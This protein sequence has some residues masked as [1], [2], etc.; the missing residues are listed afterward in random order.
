MWHTAVEEY[1]VEMWDF[2]IFIKQ[3]SIVINIVFIDVERL[4]SE[5]IYCVCSDWK[6]PMPDDR[7]FCSHRLLMWRH[8]RCRLDV[9]C[10][11]STW[12]YTAQ[13]VH[14]HH[15]PLLLMWLGFLC[16]RTWLFLS[17]SLSFSLSLSLSLSLSILLIRLMWLIFKIIHDNV[18]F[19]F[20][21]ISTVFLLPVYALN[22]IHCGL[23][24]L[25]NELIWWTVW[26]RYG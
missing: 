13:C 4:L 14:I 10:S 23:M 16:L 18:I 5:V 12:W 19:K 21:D 26:V 9:P 8:N 7:A 17:L 24:D 2:T 22:H 6:R 3:F 1:E 15:F 25:C 20:Y 11:W